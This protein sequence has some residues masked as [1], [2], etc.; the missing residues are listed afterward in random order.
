[1]NL[2]LLLSD[3]PVL[4]HIN[5]NLHDHGY[6]VGLNPKFIELTEL[7]LIREPVILEVDYRNCDRE[8]ELKHNPDCLLYL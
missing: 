8:A 1:V 5:E 7:R 4:M 2:I 6:N 3:E